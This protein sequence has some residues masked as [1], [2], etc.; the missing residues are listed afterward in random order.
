MLSNR[1][2]S[3]QKLGAFFQAKR[4][5]QI[6]WATEFSLAILLIH[7]IVIS[8]YEIALIAL[9]TMLSLTPVHLLVKK[10]QVDKASSLLLFILTFIITYLMWN[11]GGMHDEVVLGVPC[12]MI[13]AAMFGN[14]KSFISLLIIFSS[15]IALNSLAN[16]KGWVTNIPPTNDVHSAI[17][18]LLLI[19]L[20]SF[21]VWVS[22]MDFKSLLLKLRKENAEVLSSKK[23]IEN[24]LLHDVLTGLPN[25]AMAEI[26]LNKSIK[27]AKRDNT[28]VYLMFIDLD[29]FKLIN[30]ALG[31]Q[32]GD[33]LLIE[34]STRLQNILRPCDTICRFAGDEFIIIFDH[35]NSEE[36]MAE[37]SNKI[38]QAI[39]TPFYFNS[40]EFICGCSIGIT[41]SPDD[42]SD[43]ESLLHNADIAMYV[44][45][46]S[47]GN[48]FHY[49]DTKMDNH[50]HDYLNLINELRHAIKENQF[51]LTY[52][53]KV[54]LA[55]KRITGAE[56]L[57][58]WQHPTKGVV[59]PDKFIPEAEKS[60]LIIEIGEWVLKHACLTCKS[61]I[62]LGYED[63]SVA[64]N[65]SSQ[66]FKQN[67][68]YQ[69]IE[70]TLKQT[71]L[72][73][74]HLE[75]EMTESLLIENSDKLK[76]TFKDIRGLGVNL[77]IDDFGTGYS[78]LSYLKEFD[79]K[80]LKIDRSFVTDVEKNDKNK[81][82]VKAIIQMAKGLELTTVGEGVENQQVAE[83]LSDFTCDYAQGYLW[84]KPIKNDDFIRFAKEYEQS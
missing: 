46:S 64:V 53:P 77:S 59:Y 58:R 81:A 65:V 28:K 31:H 38:I 13:M 48:N 27:T 66:Q 29:N 7:R 44:S 57:I 16:Y 42:G 74:K 69:L 23:E 20:I 68:I 3:Q 71:G 55:N 12:L 24:L 32:A 34:I 39:K 9:I 62:S 75:L 43:F 30:D 41:V 8:S 11:H 19:L 56:A 51:F 50:G 60:G 36:I 45:K 73:G 17:L 5:I 35:I 14:K 26:T 76:Q 63:F 22:A 1:S 70:S 21:S 82:L 49:F 61:W 10:Q 47:G 40:N 37:I 33:A 18:I 52:Q 6:F 15:S 67:N 4:L 72:S 79:I 2:P 25:R 84:S 78:N 83:L 80:T 54:D